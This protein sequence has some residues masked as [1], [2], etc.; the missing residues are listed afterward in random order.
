VASGLYLLRDGQVLVAYGARRVPISRAQ[1]R[2]NGYRPPVD[3]LPA[4]AWAGDELVHAEALRA[5]A[6]DDWRTS[7]DD[8][9][10]GAGARAAVAGSAPK[11]MP[12]REAGS[13]CG[14]R[15]ANGRSNV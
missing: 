10:Y 12:A 9:A 1:Y 4:E 8:G 11:A 13:P 7:A 14:R 3:K 2:A 15:L 6:S 5:L